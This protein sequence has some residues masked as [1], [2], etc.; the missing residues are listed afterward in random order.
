MTMKTITLAPAKINRITVS[1]E[2]SSFTEI[3]TIAVDLP[4]GEYSLY[5]QTKE[6]ILQV[7]T[8]IEEQLRIDRPRSAY[9][10]TGKAFTLSLDV[11]DRYMHCGK[12]VYVLKH[13]VCVD[14]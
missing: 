14:I 4:N 3:V 5:S 7:N 2:D 13:Y 6:A 9:D 12:L 10:C 11:I 8:A 1:G